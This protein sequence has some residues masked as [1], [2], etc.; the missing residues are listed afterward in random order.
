MPRSSWGGSSSQIKP[1]KKEVGNTVTTQG[2]PKRRLKEVLTAAKSWILGHTTVLAD[3]EFILEKAGKL[4]YDHRV[5]LRGMA[6]RQESAAEL[7]MVARP[8]TPVEAG[9]AELEFLGDWLARWIALCFPAE[10]QLRDQVLREIAIWARSPP[11]Q[12]VY[13]DTNAR[14]LRQAPPN[15]PRSVHPCADR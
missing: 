12:F 7:V 2:F 4:L 14:A 5:Y 15:R 1:S 3:V 10:E 6:I 13:L 8:R 9:A 11:H